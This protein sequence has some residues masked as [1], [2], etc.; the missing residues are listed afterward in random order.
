MPG[1]IVIVFGRTTDSPPHARGSLLSFPAELRLII[2]Q[3][4]LE[5]YRMPLSNIVGLYFSCKFIRNEIHHE[6]PAAARRVLQAKL[7]RK[8]TITRPI[9][10]TSCLYLT[11]INLGVPRGLLE[12]SADLWPQWK[13][14]VALRPAFALRLRQLVLYIDE[15]TE[16]QTALST[17]RRHAQMYDKRTT[18]TNVGPLAARINCLLC[19]EI[20]CLSE[21]SMHNEYFCM[22]Q[23]PAYACE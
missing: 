23:M 7:S 6:F 19:P 3:L 2:Y 14:F 22:L 5:P 18:R 13:W 21:H 20:C 12:P 10:S 16:T 15:K 4:L 17:F 9:H 8:H 11:R 1:E